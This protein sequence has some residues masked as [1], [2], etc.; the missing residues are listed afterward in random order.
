MK[1]VLYGVMFFSSS[2][3]AQDIDISVHVSS[4]C[5]LKTPQ[6]INLVVEKNDDALHALYIEEE[7]FEVVCN[8][9][10][11]YTLRI[12][13]VSSSPTENNHNE[14]VFPSRAL[15]RQS[16]DLLTLKVDMLVNGS[17]RG[18]RLDANGIGTA[19]IYGLRLQMDHPQLVET[20]EYKTSL[21]ATLLY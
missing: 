20:G 12:H 19:Q 13:D 7:F 5:T 10:L 9:H 18:M 21:N 6:N 17:L 16:A 8:Q 2:V 1:F 11:P 15:A 4:K 3:F 14:V